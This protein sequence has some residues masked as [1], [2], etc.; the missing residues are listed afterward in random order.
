MEKATF[1]G[2]YIR[3]EFFSPRK[4]KTNIIVTPFYRALMM[5]TKNKLKQEIN[6]IKKILLDNE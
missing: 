1:S 2:E 4:P 5:R 3:W 6:F